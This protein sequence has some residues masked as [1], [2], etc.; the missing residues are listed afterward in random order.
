MEA[1][2]EYGISNTVN[3]EKLKTWAEIPPAD[4]PDLKSLT[5]TQEIHHD[6]SPFPCDNNLNKKVVLWLGDIVR[7]N[8]DAIVN[9]SNEALNEIN[10]LSDRIHLRSGPQLQDEIRRNLKNCRTGDAKITSGYNLPAKHV[11]H[12]VGPK[13]NLKYQTAAES[14]LFSCY[15][16]VLHIAKKLTLC[17]KSIEANTT[18]GKHSLFLGYQPIDIVGSDT[19]TMCLENKLST[20]ALC[21]INS[22]RRGYPAEEGAHIA[23]RTIRRFLEKHGEGINCIV[24]AVENQ[25]IG[26]YELIM[27]LYFPRNEMEEEYARY[28]LPKDVGNEDGEPVIADR[29]IRIATR[30]MQTEVSEDADMSQDFDSSVIIGNHSFSKMVDDVDKKKLSEPSRSSAAAALLNRPTNEEILTIELQRKNKYERLLRRAQNEDFSEISS[31]RAMYQSGVDKF[32]RPVIVFVGR[33]IKVEELDFD[34][35]LLYLIHTL[36]PI[37]QKD[38]IIVYLHTM[39]TKDNQIPV[40][41][42]KAFYNTLDYKYKKHLKAFYMVHPTFWS[43]IMSWWFTMFTASH[44]K[45]KL[46]N[47]SGIEYLYHSIN[48]DQLDIPQFV[49]EYDYKVSILK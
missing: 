28:N 9:S 20:I 12:T 4:I 29:M 34:K 43:K 49:I 15:R 38:F 30:P 5:G 14:A 10:T 46:V 36:D 22:I 16:K 21:I 37:V 27:P 2:E 39:T 26:V 23:L 25:D 1:R 7:L 40:S 47:L 17:L 19:P 24:F 3:V 33:M 31:L 42:L 18:D 48:A 11:I 44:L 13:Y 41:L 32:G 8:A 35:A 45:H 6:A